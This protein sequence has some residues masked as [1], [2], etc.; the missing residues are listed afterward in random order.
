MPEAITFKRLGPSDLDLLLSVRDGLFDKA[1]DPGQARAR[2]CTSV[3]MGTET[4]N[5]AA[6]GLSQ[7]LGGEAFPFVSN[8]W[9]G[10]PAPG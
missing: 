8:G 1:I 4:G 10:T 2:V 3:R 6:R 5:A 9:D 7:G